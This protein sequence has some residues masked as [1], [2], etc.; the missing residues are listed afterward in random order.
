[1]APA[2][3]SIVGDLDLVT[4][5]HVGLMQG[6]AQRVASMRPDLVNS[7]A[8]FGELAW[9]RAKGTLATAGPG[10]AGCGARATRWWR[11][12]GPISRTRS[13]GATGRWRTLPG[14]IWGTRSTPATRR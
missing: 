5:T 11:G 9:I 4:A 7:D 6:L 8:L 1:M 3:W 10:R 2:E 14:P 12:A 13:G